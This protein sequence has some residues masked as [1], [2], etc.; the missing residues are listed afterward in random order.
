[1]NFLW[2]VALFEY[3]RNVFKKS[4]ILLLISVPTFITFSIGLGVFLES[5]EVNPLPVGYVDE[6]GVF[7]S[8]LTAPEIAS[9]WNAEN[10]EGIAFIAYL[11]EDEATAALNDGV[12]QAYY[13]L[14]QDYFETRRVEQIY[15]EKPGKNAARQFY[16][17][18]Q[19][20]LLSSQPPEFALRAATGTDVLVR[21]IDGKR[22]VSSDGPTFGLLMP[23]FMTMGFLFMILMSSGYALSAV[24]DEKEIRTMEVLVTSISPA[25]LITGKILGITAIGLTLLFTWTLEILAGIAVSRQLGV[26]WFMDLSMDWRIIL[27]TLAV[28]IPA[29][30][31]TIALMTAIGAMVT[32]TQEGQSVSSIFFILHL[33]PLYISFIFINDPHGSL[34]VI[35]SLSPF[36]ALMTIGMRNLF[37]IVPPWQIFV[38][39][40]VQIVCALGTFWLAGRSLRLGMLRY[41]QRLTWRGL[42]GRLDRA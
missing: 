12:I 2:R 40:G 41:G 29:Y 18:M 4:F 31:L 32:T 24:A 8:V 9:T 13:L 7:A 38:S 30:A 5:S 39:V 11:S 21:S 10:D 36:T 17:F 35:L 33:A 15:I 16:D 19:L 28:G 20:N 6:A 1:M 22:V 14:P 37:T 25:R 23:L 3:R 34:G 26:S 42:L 27:A